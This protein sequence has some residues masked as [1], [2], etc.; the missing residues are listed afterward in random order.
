[1]QAQKPPKKSANSLRGVIAAILDCK[2]LEAD[3]FGALLFCKQQKSLGEMKA[4]I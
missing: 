3:S 1:M 2:M 4:V